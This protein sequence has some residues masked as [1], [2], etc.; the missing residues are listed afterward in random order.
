VLALYIIAA[1]LSVLF[2]GLLA[3]GQR[4]ARTFKP[5]PIGE[6]PAISVVIAA[7][8]EARHLPGLVQALLN[9]DYA[10]EWEVVL[11]LDR[12]ED[13]S[14]EVL[15]G[16]PGAGPRVRV[17]EIADLPE[18]WTG[19]KWA[20]EQGIRAARHEWI[21]LTDADCLPQGGWL[22]GMAGEFAGGA[23]LVLGIGLYRQGGGLLNA[24]VRFETHLTAMQYLGMAGWGR[25]YMGVGRNLGY[26]R[27]FFQRAGGMGAIAH[28]LSGDDDLLVNRHARAASTA[29]LTT[30]GT[31]TVSEPPPDWKAWWRQKLRHLSAGTGYRWSTT[32]ILS[33]LHGLQ[34]IFYLSLIGVLCSERPPELVWG[35]YAGRTVLA[36]IFWNSGNG[37]RMQ[38]GLWL[39]YP[40]LDFFYLCYHLILVPV[41][42]FLKPKWK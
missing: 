26:N 7:R 34:A 4:R 22:R 36:A 6:N 1:S 18:G 16:L 41:S 11:V 35:I 19:K 20:L 39:W 30:P 37:F 24:F 9:Q 2:P 3:W 25:P 13:D 31:H 40:L 17:L 33:L 32:F 23:E 12:C 42:L 28:R 15:R 27:S 21:A 14:E 8:N 29:T 10:G 5:D 38:K